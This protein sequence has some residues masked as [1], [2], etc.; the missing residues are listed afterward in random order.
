MR[1][2]RHGQTSVSGAPQ[3]ATPAG[4]TR[5]SLR[6]TAPET[7]RHSEGCSL[8]LAVAWAPASAKVAD[9]E[10]LTIQARRQPRRGP[11]QLGSRRP[12]VRR[13]EP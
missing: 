12:K 8:R 3:L 5:L 4:A 11:D 10:A 13:R 1:Q 2:G 6:R 9:S 7:G